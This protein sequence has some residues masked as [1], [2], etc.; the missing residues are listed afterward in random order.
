MS[1][2]RIL[3]GQCSLVHQL[4]R[5]VLAPEGEV[6]F[7]DEQLFFW[8]RIPGGLSQASSSTAEQRCH[9]P[10]VVGANP[11]LPIKYESALS[12][13]W[14]WSAL[15]QQADRSAEPTS[16]SEGAYE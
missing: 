12:V 16:S 8:V 15:S 1:K 9:M 11:T 5:W 6:R 3:P 2:V 13:S 4:G 7:L 10:T 14:V